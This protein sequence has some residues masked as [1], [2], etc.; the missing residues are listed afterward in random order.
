MGAVLGPQAEFDRRGGHEAA[1][2]HSCTGWLA[3]HCG[4]TARSAREQVRVARA[5]SDL[6]LVRAAFAAGRLSYSKV[7]ALTRVAVPEMEA[8]LIELAEDA[9]AAQLER[10]MRGYRAATA[11]PSDRV[12]ERR[13]L[14]TSW[15][16]D[17]GLVI[18]GYLPPDEGAQ[19][20]QALEVAREALAAGGG[21]ASESVG[22]DD[23]RDERQRPS[24][25]NAD[26]LLALAEAAV[27]KGV[28]PAAGGDR[29]QVVVHVEE[30]DLAGGG[31]S[32]AASCGEGFLPIETVRRI[33]CDASIVSLVERDGKP[34]S[35]GRKT[36]SVPPSIAR[37]LRARDGGCRFPGCDRTRWVDAHHVK[38]WA[39]GG[40][41]SLENLVQLCRHHH[42]LVHDG[43]FTVESKAEGPV[44]RTPSGAV[45][46]PSPVPPRRASEGIGAGP[47]TSPA[48]GDCRP[49][50]AGQPMDLDLA[51]STLATMHGRRCGDESRKI[52]P[53]DL[54]G[55]RSPG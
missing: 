29:H 52:A 42:R 26:A 27:A 20:L 6:P 22:H 48:R 30:S 45:I 13:R 8:E 43:G 14:T 35:V 3:W 32:G 54:V 10:L 47:A 41:T 51:V 34:L 50:S 21:D 36:R 12:A 40:E 53:R 18:R 1:G 17:G 9:T 49:R 15:D 11:A 31:R 24:L 7:R 23:V 46:E 28:A 37:A 19:L 55:L 4:L 33:A 5:L 2:F 39:H 38:H 25:T 44:F 16:D